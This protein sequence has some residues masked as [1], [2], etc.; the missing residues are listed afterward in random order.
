MSAFRGKADMAIA[1]PNVRSWTQSGRSEAAS[2]WRP[3]LIL[4][5]SARVQAAAAVHLF[6]DDL[7]DHFTEEGATF[8]PFAK[9]FRS[10]R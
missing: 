5:N 2:L 6:R 10:S 7:H 1:L 8:M 9:H 3:L 4:R